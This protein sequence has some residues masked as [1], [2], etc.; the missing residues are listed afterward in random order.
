CFPLQALL[1]A[2]NLTHVNFVSLD[3]EGVEDQVLSSFW[4]SGIEVDVWMVEHLNSNKL[5]HEKDVIDY[6]F[7]KEFEL[8]GYSL[9]T[10][11]F[12]QPMDYVFIR[13]G[14]KIHQQSFKKKPHIIDKACPFWNSKACTDY[15]QNNSVR[16]TV[17]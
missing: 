17:K 13:N 12:G 11:H 5:P 2:L 8:Q 3:V 7:I 16:E 10:I 14:T 15:D 4:G 9:Y 1:N 6:Q